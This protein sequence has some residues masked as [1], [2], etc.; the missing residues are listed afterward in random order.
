MKRI[1]NK[2]KTYVRN[3]RLAWDYYIGNECLCHICYNNTRSECF[4]EE[5]NGKEDQGVGKQNKSTRRK[6]R[7]HKS[8]NNTTIKEM[9]YN[10]LKVLRQKMVDKTATQSEKDEF[11]EMLNQYNRITKTDYKNYKKGINIEN[12][13]AFSLMV[14]GLIVISWMVSEKLKEN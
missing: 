9:D 8:I 3:S 1:I 2:I 13:I 11:I 6:N 12:I 5:K 14:A 7:D 10:R 4:H